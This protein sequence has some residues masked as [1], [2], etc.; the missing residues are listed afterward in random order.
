MSYFL[1]NFIPAGGGT[2]ILKYSDT[3]FVTCFLFGLRNEMKSIGKIGKFKFSFVFQELNGWWLRSSAYQ[4][5]P[6]QACPFPSNTNF[7][8][9][10]R[11]SKLKTHSTYKRNELWRVSNYLLIIYDGRCIA[12]PLKVLRVCVGVFQELLGVSSFQQSR[13]NIITRAAAYLSNR[14]DF[15]PYLSVLHVFKTIST[16][17]SPLFYFTIWKD[18]LLLVAVSQKLI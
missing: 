17:I 9:I 6:P 15:L 10:F 18:A 13:V 5:R 11:E 1:K 4:N 2:K 3:F 14:Y 7:N 8:L 16:N 12:S